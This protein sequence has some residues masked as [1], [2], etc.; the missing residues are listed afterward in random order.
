[1]GK[2]ARFPLMLALAALLAAGCSALPG[3]RVLTGQDAGDAAETGRVVELTGLVMAD[4]SGSVD[5]SLVAAADRIEAAASGA[6]DIIEIRQNATDDVFD[7][8]MLYRGSGSS[9]QEQNDALRRALELTWQGTMQA[10]QGSDLVR[11]NMIQPSLV[12]TLDKGMSF[13]GRIAATFEI[14]RENLIVYLAKRPT[15]LQSFVNLILDGTIV[16]AEPEQTTFYEGQPNHSVFMLADIEAQV[17][18]RQTGQ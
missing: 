15:T 7:I 9:A 14:S 4:K 1:M 18:A 13:A 12:P 10:S 3:L 5:P 11:V 6:V 2:K 16:Y 8:F 17:R